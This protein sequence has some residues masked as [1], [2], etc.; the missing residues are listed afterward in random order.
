MKVSWTK[1][2]ENI[3]MYRENRG[4]SVEEL[5]QKSGETADCVKKAEE[6]RRRIT[7]ATALALC[8]ALG[9]TPNELLAGVE[10]AI[11]N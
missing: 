10:N 2:G 3:R 7:L 8:N 11:M 9:I 5:A 4:M 6:G 1:M